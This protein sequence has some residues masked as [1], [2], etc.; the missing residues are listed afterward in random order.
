MAGIKLDRALEH[1]RRILSLP[2]GNID[3]PQVKVRTVPVWVPV[4]SG[5]MIASALSRWA[6][7]SSSWSWTPMWARRPAIYEPRIASCTAR[8]DDNETASIRKV[9]LLHQRNSSRAAMLI[10][11]WGAQ[12]SEGICV[13][14]R[15]PMNGL[16]YLW[17]E[18]L[19]TQRQNRGARH[20]AARHTAEVRTELGPIPGIVWPVP[21]CTTMH[22][23]RR[24]PRRLARAEMIFRKAA[25]YVMIQA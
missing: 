17:P 10:K 7:G 20:C 18:A 23:Q 24:G 8:D 14:I 15:V 22:M 3:Q 9:F 19:T 13:K 6:A 25:D 5:R 21:V 16:C 2:A 4:V 1:A 11:A 12:M